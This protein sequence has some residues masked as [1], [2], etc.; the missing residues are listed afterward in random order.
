MRVP[1]LDG[2]SA[3][4]ENE[5]VANIETQERIKANRMLMIRCY[6]TSD[7][8][9]NVR[10]LLRQ[11]RAA[12]EFE[13]FKSSSILDGTAENPEWLSNDRRNFAS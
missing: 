6:Q 8:T 5:V 11:G 12:L 13:P 7:S 4:C 9:M 2:V 10:A 1:S 3:A